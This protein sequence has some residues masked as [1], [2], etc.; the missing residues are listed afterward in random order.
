MLPK[1]KERH[2][3]QHLKPVLARKLKSATKKIAAE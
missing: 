3:G 2:T 1:I